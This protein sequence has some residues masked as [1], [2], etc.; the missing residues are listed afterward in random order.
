MK[1]SF[2]KY[3]EDLEKQNLA[4]KETNKSLLQV[5]KALMINEY[6]TQK[7]IDYLNDDSTPQGSLV[8]KGIDFDQSN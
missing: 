3:K 6:D 5:K 1:Y 2:S 4:V 7:T 8:H